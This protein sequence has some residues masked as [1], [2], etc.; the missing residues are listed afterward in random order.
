MVGHWK[1][2]N[3]KVE[4]PKEGPFKDRVNQYIHALF[5]LSNKKMIALSDMR[6]FARIAFGEKEKILKLK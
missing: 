6:K 5:Y 1:I 4:T 2:R 3:G